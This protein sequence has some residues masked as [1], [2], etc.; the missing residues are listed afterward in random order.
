MDEIFNYFTEEIGQR[1]GSVFTTEDSVR[2][3]F[4]HALTSKSKVQPNDVIL[5]FP[6]PLIRN[7]QIDTY[8]PSGLDVKIAMEFKYDRRT[9]ATAPRSQKAGKVLNDIYRLSLINKEFAE[10]RLFIY[11]TD[12]EMASYFRNPQN[13]LEELFELSGSNDLVL[14]SSLT[15]GKAQTLLNNIGG[16]LNCRVKSVLKRELPNNHSLRI[17]EL[18]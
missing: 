3:T 14:D 10:K 1:L 7:A 11:L 13:G 18:V 15:V 17:Y 4:F 6:H 12:D 16:A 9:E 8:I 5:E 2:Y